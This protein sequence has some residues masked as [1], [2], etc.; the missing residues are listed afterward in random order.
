MRLP[1][2]ARS[3][4]SIWNTKWILAAVSGLF[5]GFSYPPLDLPFLQI[6]AFVLLFR[7]ADLSHSHR[8][9]AYWSFFSFLLW[10]LIVTYWL[11]MATLAGGI[12]AIL[13]NSALMTIP[14]VLQRLVLRKSL[15]WY[16]SI[17]LL[18]SLWLSYEYLHHLWD[19]AWPWL[20]LGNG[21]ANYPGLIQYISVTGYLGISFWVV[22]SA[23][24]F[25]F[26]ISMRFR[27]RL[28][29][30]AVAVLMLPPAA[31]LTYQGLQPVAEKDN[32]PSV[33]LVIGQ[34]DF[35]S[36]ASNYGYSDPVRPLHVLLTLTDSLRNDQTDAVIWP[37]NAVQPYI[38]N[39]IM[40]NSHAN[41]IRQILQQNSNTWNIPIITGATYFE[42]FHADSSSPPPLVRNPDSD[43]PYIY[44]NSAIGFRPT[45]SMKVYKKVHLVPMVERIP[46]LTTLHQIDPFGINWHSLPWYGK[47]KSYTQFKI[48]NTRTPALVCYDSVFPH[49]MRGFIQ[50]GAG[51]LTIITNDG[52]WGDTGGHIQHFAYARLRAIE[53]RRWVARSANNG[54]SGL[55]APTGEIIQ[56]T[57]YGEQT[58]IRIQVPIR[59]DQTI[60][61]RYGGWLPLLCLTF[62]SVSLLFLLIQRTWNRSDL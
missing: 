27:R 35:D 34:P 32:G 9:A 54:I 41:R 28:M 2:I 58:V 3:I 8:E 12:A 40:D 52:W 59:E 50:R 23:S 36:Y 43:S 45:D 46:Y 61:A 10:N 13:A 19:L 30:L 26:C 49:W 20:A 14:L 25:H 56:R 39:R 21:W 60:F 48:A 24:L 31:S 11:M 62:V 53:F 15:P 47:G 18:P 51:F 38:G 44:Y 17:L 55:I 29:I 4:H 7:L 42:Y 1:G 5:L 6:A 16:M 57:V 33:Q 22:F 37:E